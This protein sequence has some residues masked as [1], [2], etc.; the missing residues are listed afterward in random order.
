MQGLSSVN[1][2]LKKLD[3]F[4]RAYFGL[5][6][7]DQA[8]TPRMVEVVCDKVVV[9]NTEPF[10]RHLQKTSLSDLEIK[11]LSQ[12]NQQKLGIAAGKAIAD[13]LIISFQPPSIKK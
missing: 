5:T 2:I 9:T 10:K 11:E 1:K 8:A 13:N 6:K 4:S 12:V 3:G 7:I